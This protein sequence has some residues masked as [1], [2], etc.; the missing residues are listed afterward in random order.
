MLVT[1]FVALALSFFQA[2][3]GAPAIPVTFSV[4]AAILG[5]L[6]SLWLIYRVLINPPGGSAKLGAFI[7]LFAALAIAYGGYSSMRLEGIAPSDAA[8][9]TTVRLGEQGGT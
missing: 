1:V 8:E 7:G 6:S 5:G 3:R 9:I 2:R 4:L